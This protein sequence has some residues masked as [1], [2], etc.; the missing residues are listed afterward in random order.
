MAKP[1][2]IRVPSD[3]CLVEVAGEQFAV[4]EGEWVEVLPIMKARDMQALNALGSVGDRMAVAQGDPTEA[5]QISEILDSA[6]ADVAELLAERVR[7]WSWTDMDGVPLPQPK[8]DP[9]VITQLTT[10]EMFYLVGLVRGDGLAQRKKDLSAWQTTSSD[11]APVPIQS[12]S[13]SVLSRMPAI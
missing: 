11:S 9:E 3:D 2:A 6:F 13:D 5:L 7:A 1:Q 4:H 10:D 8:G 12:A